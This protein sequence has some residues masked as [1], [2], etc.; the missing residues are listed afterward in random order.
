MSPTVGGNEPPHRPFRARVLHH[1]LE[2]VPVFGPVLALREIAERE[3]S[4]S[5]NRRRF[6]D[7][8][9][10]HFRTSVPLRVRCGW[11]VSMSSYRPARSPRRDRWAAECPV[12]GG[13]RFDHVFLVG[14]V[15]RCGQALPTFASAL[16]VSFDASSSGAGA[17]SSTRATAGFRSGDVAVVEFELK[18]RDG[19]AAQVL[20]FTLPA[21]PRR[22]ELPRARSFG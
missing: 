13:P 15:E 21:F 8:L 5:R 4:L 14:P 12:P 7:T 6:F 2:C 17:A 18:A 16:D 11:N 3:P 22:S 19:P 10:K 9:R 20:S 1:L